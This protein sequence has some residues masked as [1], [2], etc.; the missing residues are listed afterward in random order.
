MSEVPPNA[1]PRETDGGWLTRERALT[2]VLLVVTAVAFYVCYRLVLPFL[3]ALAWALALAVVAHPLHGWIERRLK[4][5]NIA[6]G[7]AV[8]LVAVTL[9]AP[10]FFV[11]KSVVREAARWAETIRQ[12]I[13]TGAWRASVES[14]PRLAAALRW[15][16]EGAEMRGVIEQVTDAA[17]A[18]IS[19]F[20]VGSVRAVA[21]LLITLFALFYFFRDR[22]VMLRALRRLVPLSDGET[23]EIFRRVRDTLYATIYGTLVVA[24]VQGVLGGLMFWWLGLPAPLLWGAVMALVAIV[25]VLGAFVVWVPAA[26]ILAA[27]GSWGKALIL[28]IWGGVVVSLIDN[29]LYP[30][31]VGNKLRIHTLPVFIA[32]V[33]GLLLFGASGI[34]LGTVALATTIALVDVWRRRTAGGGRRS[35]GAVDVPGNQ[36]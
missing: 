31:L 15:V 2:F 12:Q 11:T 30:A 32:I 9:V 28:T 17:P 5:P 1:P 22:G 21:E 10:A 29:L 8:A 3:P 23:D 7:L 20:V 6:A 18:G 25:P 34:V 27:G 33:G 26:I 13:E 4:R 16:E 19:Q 14:N 35:D 36:T 24:L